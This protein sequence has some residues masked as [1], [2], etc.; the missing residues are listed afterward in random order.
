[1]RTRDYIRGYKEGLRDASRSRRKYHDDIGQV[2]LMEVYDSDQDETLETI[3]LWA[4]SDEEAL[5]LFDQYCEQ[6]YDASCEPGIWLKLSPDRI[7]RYG[8]QAS[9]DQ[10]KKL[11]TAIKS[12][13]L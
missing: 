3:F 6:T 10:A 2:Y 8:D 12:N 9:P 7:A 11:T 5:E 13:N 4:T 1:M